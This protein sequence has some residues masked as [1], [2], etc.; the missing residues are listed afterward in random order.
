MGKTLLQVKDLK[1]SYGDHQVLNGIN[2]KINPGM[3][4][5]LLGPNG[6][7]KTSMIKSIVGLIND[8]EGEILI[9]GKKPGVESKKSIAYLPEK[10]YLPAWMTPKSAIKYMADFYDNFNKDKAYELLHAFDLPEKQKIKTM[11]KGMQEK[12]QLL[13]V[14]SREAKLY[15]LDEPLGGV[16]PVARDFIM[17]TIMKNRFENS[18]ILLST[19]LIYDIEG[20]LDRVLMIKGGNLEVD[21]DVKNIDDHGMTVEDLFKEVFRNVF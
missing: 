4:V 8:Y 14:M 13:L 15:I 21:T 19:H 9:E 1:K 6:C 5:G 16:D 3:I 11:S 20:I 17:E 12:V 10:N 7:G 2:F 18:S